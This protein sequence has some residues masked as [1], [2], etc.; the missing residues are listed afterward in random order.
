MTIYDQLTVFFIEMIK[1]DET[2][3]GFVLTSV[4]PVKVFISMYKLFIKE[5]GLIPIENLLVEDKMK[6]WNECK[7]TGISKDKI[8]DAAK[9]LHTLK[10][11]NENS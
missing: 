7:A 5:N 2:A 3:L 9:I 11:I 6:L 4:V 1:R 10:F 8:V